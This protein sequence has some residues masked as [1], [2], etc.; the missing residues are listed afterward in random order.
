MKD[1]I[2]FIMAIFMVFVKWFFK[3]VFSP[4]FFSSYSHTSFKQYGQKV[5]FNQ[6]YI[7]SRFLISKVTND[8]LKTLQV[9]R[10]AGAVF[11]FKTFWAI[12]L[13]K[14]FW[15]F[16]DGKAIL[17]SKKRFICGKRNSRYE[18]FL[19]SHN[20]KFST[21]RPHRWRQWRW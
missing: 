9:L 20:R 1:F 21:M 5:N 7:L 3:L 13:S 14:D 16:F 6:W 18:L 8:T 19:T 4:I 17:F 11:D 2:R 15:V 12:P 10:S